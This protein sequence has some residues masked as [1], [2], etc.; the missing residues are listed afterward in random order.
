M[1]PVFIMAIENDDDR[2]FVAELYARCQPAMQRRALSILKN[3]S[4]AEEA[5]HEAILR[6][7]RHLEKVRMIPRDEVLYY[8]V[9]VTETA[10]MQ[11]DGEL[12]AIA[13]KTG[14]EAVWALAWAYRRFA[15]QHRELYW[16]VM[17]TAAGEPRVLDD[18]A[19]RFTEPLKQVLSGFRLPPREEI[20]FRRMFR[21]IVHGFA[22][23][24]DEGFFSHYPAS[25]ELSFEFA[26]QRFIDC[27]LEAEKRN[28]S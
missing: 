15:Q 8:L 28:P 9:T 3:E 23:Q 12:R 26:I 14:R 22:S 4:D 21:A 1:L 25:T 5:V 16:L 2:T 17:D 11:E 10:S 19:A 27:V 18:A 24:E 13:G 6:V 7:I 20:H